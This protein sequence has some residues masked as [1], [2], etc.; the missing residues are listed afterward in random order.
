TYLDGRAVGL[1]VTAAGWQASVTTLE[2]LRSIV[3]AL[4]GWPTPIGASLNTSEPVFD[5]YGNCTDAKAA[6]ALDAV[7]RQ[8]VEFA[9]HHSATSKRRPPGR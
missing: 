2:A 1:V 4:R 8:V 3:H 7:G 9:A 6:N 5:A